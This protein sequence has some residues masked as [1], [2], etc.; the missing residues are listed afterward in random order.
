LWQYG[1]PGGETVFD[2]RMG[3]G[4]EGPHKFLGQWEGILQTDG[5]QAYDRVGGPKLVHVGCWA[6]ARRKFVDA[7]KVNRDDAAAIQ[8]VMRM[9][10][11]FLVDR[12]AREKQMTIEERL[13]ARREHAEVWAEEIRQECTKLALTVLPKSTLGQAVHYTLNMW[14]KLR[15]CFD[16]AEVELSNN[17]AENSMRP[18]ALGRKNWLHVGSAK[19]GPKVAAIVSVVESCRRL[20]M[21]VKEYLLD[22]LPGMDRRKLSEIGQL[23]PSRWAAARL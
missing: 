8:M 15:R 14:P 10:A 1:K 3:R 13:V 7:V 11:L 18:V 23:T 20:R 6:H 12:D 21:P 9:E 19:A 22:I 2:F 5:Y 16:Y 4:R 17:L